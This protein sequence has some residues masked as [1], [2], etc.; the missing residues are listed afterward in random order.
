M[1]IWK[2][3]SPSE[4]EIELMEEFNIIKLSIPDIT[5]SVKKCKG[6]NGV[7]YEYILLHS[8]VEHNC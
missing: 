8:K 1:G 3:R 2:I 4:K 5:E 7:C 6:G